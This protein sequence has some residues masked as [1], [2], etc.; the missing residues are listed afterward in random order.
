MNKRLVSVWKV[1]EEKEIWIKD[2]VRPE[3][4]RHPGE[5]MP[6]IQSRYWEEDTG[7]GPGTGKTVS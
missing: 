6:A 7:T 4:N 5:V 2:E 1:I 3:M